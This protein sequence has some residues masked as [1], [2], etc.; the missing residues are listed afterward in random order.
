MKIL[1]IVS[2]LS[3]LLFS[4]TVTAGAVIVKDEANNPLSIVMVSQTPVNGFTLD[5]SDSGYPPVGVVNRSNRT[6]SQFTDENG[7][8]IFQQT[9]DELV[10]YRLRKPDYKDVTIEMKANEVWQVTME[11]ELDPIYLQHLVLQIHG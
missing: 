6:Q 10:R 11:K 2:A 9:G 1:K 7:K 4:V 8:T 5:R 3:S